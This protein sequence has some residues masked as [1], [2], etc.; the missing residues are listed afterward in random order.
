[1]ATTTRQNKQ[2]AEIAA[3]V[4]D[5][6]F[7]NED[8]KKAIEQRVKDA[9][10]SKFN[11]ILN[12]IEKQESVIFDLEN[13]IEK[14]MK[15]CDDLDQKIA[16]MQKLQETVAKDMNNLEQYSRRNSVRIFGLKELP[17]ENTNDLIKQLARDKLSVDLIDTSIDRSHRV[18]RSAVNGRPRA[19]LVKLTSYQHKLELMKARRKL[20]GSG[21]VIAED[22]TNQNHVTLMETKKHAKVE[23]CWTWDGR[24]LAI[25]K[26]SDGHQTK[27][28]ISNVT[29][30]AK[31]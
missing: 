3:I 11:E 8:F 10:E 24:I 1:M 23:S 20:K 19:L 17:N 16:K 31:L 13:K 9:I 4:T 30:L 21:I 29:D 22:L 6:L 5:G 12:H 27:V 7:N 28:N 25:V 18:G 26:T 14:N 15:V 2:A